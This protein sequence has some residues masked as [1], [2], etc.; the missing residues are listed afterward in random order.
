VVEAFLRVIP[1]EKLEMHRLVDED[2]IGRKI[3]ILGIGSEKTQRFRITERP[4]TTGPRQ[5]R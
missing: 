1:D 5:Q 4:W 3:A 2:R